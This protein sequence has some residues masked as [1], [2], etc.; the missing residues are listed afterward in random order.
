[1]AQYQQKFPIDFSSSAQFYVATGV[2]SFL[3]AAAILAFYLLKTE[4]YAT[5]PLLP[6]IDL[7]VTGVLTVFWFAG[8]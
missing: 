8:A 2:L 4:Q 6:V 7:G 5:N 3:Y 1:M